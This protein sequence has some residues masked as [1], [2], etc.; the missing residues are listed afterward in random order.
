M[1]DS[2]KWVGSCGYFMKFLTYNIVLSF[3]ALTGTIGYQIPKYQ[4]TSTHC[5]KGKTE[6]KHN[7]GFKLHFML[8]ELL[9]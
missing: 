2:H 3:I 7:I 4:T 9:I 5:A 1:W 6:I 8:E